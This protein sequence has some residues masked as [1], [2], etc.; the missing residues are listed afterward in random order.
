MTETY[1]TILLKTNDGIG[2]VTLNRP[3]KRNALNPKFF[4]EMSLVLE[5]LIAD[6]AVRVIII[7]GS[8]GIFCAG[9]DLKEFFADHI[10]NPAEFLRNNQKATET[11]DKLRRCP[12]PTI[13]A[14]NGWCLGGGLSVMTVMDFVLAADEAKFGL[15]EINFGGIPAGGAGKGLMQLLSHRDALDLV[16]TGRNIDAAEAERLRL[17]NRCVPRSRL[18]EEC[19]A[20]A[21]E[22]K[23]KEPIALMMAK[24]TFWREKEMNYTEAL[25]AELDKV[26]KMNY[27]QKGRW[28]SDGIRK[29]LE[30]QYKTSETS[31][32]QAS[33]KKY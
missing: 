26:W 7:T 32:T 2:F 22:L 28:V 1:E 8:G 23:K 14:V 31:Y 4:D 33:P 12:K 3:E 18:M 20:I 27:L 9:N 17:V 16:L 25:E 15:P 11:L 13:A 6:D 30:K 29:F 21:N 19:I 10:D 5:R 24:E